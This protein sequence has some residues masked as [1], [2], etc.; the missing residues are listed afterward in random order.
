MPLIK[1]IYGLLLD[2]EYP[3]GSGPLL[4]GR[5]ASCAINAKDPRMSRNHAAV[6][7]KDGR[8]VIRDN[9]S[10]NGTFVNGVRIPPLETRQFFPGDDIRIG[11]LLLRYLD[12]EI[13]LGKSAIPGYTILELF[14]E[15]ETSLTFH[16][17]DLETEE[18]VAL[19]LLRPA[20]LPDA[21]MRAA[22]RE[23]ADSA[24]ILDHPHIIPVHKLVN[25]QGRMFYTRPWIPHPPLTYGMCADSSPRFVAKVGMQLA[26]ALEHAH[27]KGIFHGCLHP[28]WIHL[29][30][31]GDTLVRGFGANVRAET[32]QEHLSSF[33]APEQVEHR[34]IDGRTDLYTL[35]AILYLTLSGKPVYS[36]LTPEELQAKI[37]HDTPESLM[38]LVK[39][40][41]EPLNDILL[42]LLQRDPANRFQTAGE[43]RDAL[44]HFL[45]GKPTSPSEPGAPADAESD[46]LTE[47]GA[48][49]DTTTGS[50]TKHGMPRSATASSRR[51]GTRAAA[52][53]IGGTGLPGTTTGADGKRDD[54]FLIV[55]IATM[56]LL[57]AGVVGYHVLT[58]GG[59]TG[60]LSTTTADGTMSP[61]QR[62]N[63]ERQAREVLEAGDQD[64]ARRLYVELVNAF[65]QDDLLQTRARGIITRIDRARERDARRTAFQ[66][67]MK[68]YQSR[69]AETP[70][71]F[72]ELRGVLIELQ[73]AYPEFN[74]EIDAESQRLVTAQGDLIQILR[75]DIRILL[76][77]GEIDRAYNR[78][79]QFVV[80][81]PDHPRLEEVQALR[82]QVDETLERLKTHYRERIQHQFRANMFGRVLEII[83]EMKRDF[84]HAETMAEIA[85]TEQQIR[86]LLQTRFAPLED[87]LRILLGQRAYAEAS[88]LLQQHRPSFYGTPF[89]NRVADLTRAVN[90]AHRLQSAVIEAINREGAKPVPD[91]FNMPQLHPLREQPGEP[92]IQSANV[93]TISIRTSTAS[94]RIP[95]SELSRPQLL[96]VYNLYPPQEGTLEHDALT[97]LRPLLQR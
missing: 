7:L 81:H 23:E 42:R 12:G 94:A 69:L 60:T 10:S 35:G 24:A 37:L 14:S 2:K 84:H 95:W 82:T 47:G 80:G 68:A 17:R 58:Q 83:E 18:E 36:G 57:V 28:S 59:D 77:D 85:T 29:S 73:E 79:D 75:N 30:D 13:R 32:Q 93:E 70:G 40:C 86:T 64:T 91:N 56:L 66:Q 1:C 53:T 96:A 5:E 88:D 78:I 89:E 46:P 76:R 19:V 65:P 97:A 43:L 49:T 6:V 26:D 15:D 50:G 72:E 25:E 92:M 38:R 52:T 34:P 48:D 4:I 63:L 41:P 27:E 3:L 55:G 67:R 8:C 22:F 31:E 87:Q 21:R 62:D 74:A 9:K 45:S 71:A 11:H 61:V 54:T 39:D 16:A 33:L 90:G 20:L 44:D 51:M